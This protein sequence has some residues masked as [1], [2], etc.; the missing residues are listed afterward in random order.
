[1]INHPYEKSLVLRHHVMIQ[2]YLGTLERILLSETETKLPKITIHK[3]T[4]IQVERENCS[5]T[6]DIVRTLFELETDLSLHSLCNVDPRI[7]TQLLSTV[8]HSGINCLSKRSLSPRIMALVG[9]C[10]QR[11]RHA[12]YAL[13]RA[14]RTLL[15]GLFP[16]GSTNLRFI[17]IQLSVDKPGIT[18]EE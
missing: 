11:F 4:G 5:H 6:V 3:L 10:K 13:D 12:T 14:V 18:E 7:L 16:S 2:W 8:F 17:F 1:M 15:P 9:D